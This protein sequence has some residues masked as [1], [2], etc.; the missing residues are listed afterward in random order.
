[1]FR[2]T[3]TTPMYVLG[4]VMALLTRFMYSLTPIVKSKNDALQ[5]CYNDAFPVM[6]YIC[7][8]MQLIKLIFSKLYMLYIYILHSV[9]TITCNTEFT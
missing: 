4:K 9:H 8:H 5:V 2:I 6:G 1:M 3:H 7:K